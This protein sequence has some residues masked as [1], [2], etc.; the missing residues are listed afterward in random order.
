[1]DHIQV[2]FNKDDGVEFFGGTV[3]AKH[4][5]LSA[6]GDD[7]VDWTQ[8]WTGR[9]QYVV[10]H[11]RGD[12]ADQG[13]EGDNNASNNDLQPRANPTI[14]NATILGDPFSN[15]GNESD[16]GM[17]IREGTAG[18][19]RNFIVMG[20]KEYGLNIDQSATITQANSGALT[21]GNGIIFGNGILPSRANLDSDALAIPS[22][23]QNPTLVFDQDP[24]LTDPFN[25]TNPNFR[26]RD[27]NVPAM[28][29]PRAT[30]PSDG[31]FEQAPF[32]GALSND[33]AQD[34]TLGWTD[35]SG[36]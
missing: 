11:Q 1:V 16:D 36:F 4:L 26:P 34:W 17:L 19:I 8:G 12:D 24:G 31:F 2:K 3:D 20:F 32:I 15:F 18:T 21:F 6:N 14:F 23:A 10:I 29:L 33:P 5:V 28:T 13:F 27:V 30:P 35:Y 22:I 25:H 7:N 9:L